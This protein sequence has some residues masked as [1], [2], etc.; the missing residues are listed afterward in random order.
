MQGHTEE[1][2][3]EEMKAPQCQ[4]EDENVEVE[5]MS[6]TR[7]KRGRCLPNQLLV[8]VACSFPMCRVG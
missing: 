1:L 4:R 3:E 6:G 7:Q 2:D 5:E 8:A